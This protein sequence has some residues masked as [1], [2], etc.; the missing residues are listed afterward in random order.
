[1]TPSELSQNISNTT[2]TPWADLRLDDSGLSALDR[3]LKAA[4]DQD[5]RDSL[6]AQLVPLLTR[7]PDLRRGLDP[8]Q[9]FVE[10]TRNPMSF[11]VFLDRDRDA[12][13]SLLQILSIESTAVEW[14]VS[15]PDSFDWLRLSAGQSVDPE[16][17]KDILISE[18]KNLDEEEQILASMKRFRRRETLRVICSFCLHDMPASSVTQQLSWIADSGIAATLIAANAE[19][20]TD[21]RPRS[22]NPGPV[23]DLSNFLCAMGLGSLGGQ[24]LEFD[25]PL[26]MVILTDSEL[27]PEEAR[28]S[29]VEDELQRIALRALAILTHPEGLGYSVAFPYNPEGTIQGQVHL[30]DYRRWIREI[31]NNG[32]TW[33]RLRRN[34]TPKTR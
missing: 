14:L 2:R 3:L 18:I 32:R 28:E 17:L 22:Q 27:F 8:L 23:I 19:R 1:M 26:E 9:R 11:L 34:R 24:E 30:H 21:R 10:N 12:L 5:L 6:S 31:E 16:H 25:G 15:D 7:F 20:K 29:F 13:P 4:S 33:Q